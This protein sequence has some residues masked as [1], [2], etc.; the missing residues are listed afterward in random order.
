[1]LASTGM[2]V[3]GMGVMVAA[4]ARNETQAGVVAVLIV[5][6]MGAISGCL[7]PQVKIEGLSMITPH[8]W[9]LQGI[10]D[11]ISRGLGVSDV[12]VPAGV[13]VGMAVWT[14]LLSVF[15][16]GLTA[17]PLANWYAKRLQNA[18]TD[19][20]E[21]KDLNDLKNRRRRMTVRDS[22]PIGK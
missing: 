8:Y 18:V 2:V 1:M 4:L 15:L 16:H 19:M 14:I 21:L 12:L 3:A 13:L 9:A 7:M 5:L 11:V 6:V 22:E 17:V 20:P 10:Q